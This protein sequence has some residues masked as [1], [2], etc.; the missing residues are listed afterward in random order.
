MPHNIAIE[1]I[2]FTYVI[3]SVLCE[4][5]YGII[6]FVFTVFVF[7]VFVFNVF[8][9]N[10]FVCNVF[11][12]S[13]TT[14]MSQHTIEENKPDEVSCDPR[15][16][17]LDAISLYVPEHAAE[18]DKIRETI[19]PQPL[20]I[21]HMRKIAD[22]T[23]LPLDTTEVVNPTISFQVGS[24]FFYTTRSTLTNATDWVLNTPSG[25]NIAKSGAFFDADPDI[26]AWILLQ[27]RGKQR[28]PWTNTNIPHSIVR[29]QLDFWGLDWWCGNVSS[30][31]VCPGQDKIDTV[32]QFLL[33]GCA[34]TCIDRGVERHLLCTAYQ[35]LLGETLDIIPPYM[36]NTDDEWSYFGVHPF[37]RDDIHDDHLVTPVWLQSCTAEL[38]AYIE[39]FGITVPVARTRLSIAHMTQ[40]MTHCVREMRTHVA[41]V[42]DD[43][44]RSWLSRQEEFL[45]KTE[46]SLSDIHSIRCKRHLAALTL[47][48]LLLNDGGE[49]GRPTLS[50]INKTLAKRGVKLS[51]TNTE[52][53]GRS[54]FQ[55]NGPNKS[56][57]SRGIPV[58]GVLRPDNEQSQFEDRGYAWY[59]YIDSH[60]NQVHSAHD[61]K[62][63]YHTL[64]AMPI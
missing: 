22:V 41:L 12:F 19:G 37:T 24:R 8:V 46:K 21:E 35:H 45:S 26:F 16:A 60:L 36:T 63:V 39:G 15:E 27:L 61:N 40:K 58:F 6:V 2:L 29:Q 28:I 50:R 1:C 34:L 4:L 13:T 47:W 48:S 7:N 17:I 59:E 52:V 42:D 11:V 49:S 53:S 14:Q 20:S 3:Y 56:D 62:L 55:I 44:A 9:C 30:A 5:V 43:Q 31:V 54:V 25:F 32:C 51:I 38:V 64:R 23:V 57:Q 18:I 33:D 10:V